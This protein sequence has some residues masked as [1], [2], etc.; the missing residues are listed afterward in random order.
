MTPHEPLARQNL[1]NHVYEMIK[2]MLD[3]GAL[4]PG[5][6]IN[7]KELEEELG[8]SQTPINE[9]L[10]RLAAEKFIYQQSRRGFFVCEYSDEDLIDLFAVQAAIEA[11]AARL[12]AEDATDDEL[13]E[14]SGHFSDYE[15]PLST[16][17]HERYAAEDKVFH[18]AVIRCCHNAA[19]Q[20]MYATSGYII[21]SN[22]RGL[23]RPP[24]ETLSEHRN[25]IAAL[26]RRDPAAAS[27]EMADHQL[28]SRNHLKRVVASRDGTDRDTSAM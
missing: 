18:A 4:K 8:V 14:L 25:L 2:A 12:C 13:V 26:V 19:I 24:S 22:Q 11:M 1:T 7:K 27:S 15:L 16:E 21:K 3:A 17:E 9:A 10:N 5:A 6:K 28:R 20:D 23:V